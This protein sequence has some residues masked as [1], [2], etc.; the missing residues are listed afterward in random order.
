MSASVQAAGGREEEL[1][2]YCRAML[3][4]NNYTVGGG[5]GWSLNYLSD[6]S[7][8]LSLLQA[9]LKGTQAT[10]QQLRDLI[11]NSVTMET[12]G[13]PLI[14]ALCSMWVTHVR[15]TYATCLGNLFDMTKVLTMLFFVSS[16]SP[17]DVFMSFDR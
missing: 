4:W 7:P 17:E 6:P 10:V 16:S 3:E 1:G 8:H 9:A 15:Y 5:G 11:T 14:S 2:M 13:E 12:G